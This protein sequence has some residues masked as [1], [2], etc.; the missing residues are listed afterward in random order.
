METLN[1]TN[2]EIRKAQSEAK[3]QVQNK[4]ETTKKSVK[5][6]QG[7]IFNQFNFVIDCNSQDVNKGKD[8]YNYQSDI[9]DFLSKKDKR[10]KQ[11]FAYL[12]GLK[13]NEVYKLVNNGLMYN[14]TLIS[15]LFERAY[16]ELCYNKVNDLKVS[17]Y[18]TRGE[19]INALLLATKQE[20]NNVSILNILNFFGGASKNEKIVNL[21]AITLLTEFA[22]LTVY[23]ND[24]HLKV[25]KMDEKGHETHKSKFLQSIE[26]KSKESKIFESSI[27]KNFTQLFEAIETVEKSQTYKLTE[28]DTLE[29]FEVKVFDFSEAQSNALVKQQSKAS[30]KQAP[31]SKASTKQVAET[32]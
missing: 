20:K 22:P 3:K 29:S 5:D 13:L 27:F 25:R 30:T 14:S 26:Y 24:L 10:F 8:V 17:E 16:I 1:L 6:T 23:K 2:K 9:I 12:G 11:S 7:S 15:D 31:K 21:N 19:Q 32:V 4:F 28:N 18:A